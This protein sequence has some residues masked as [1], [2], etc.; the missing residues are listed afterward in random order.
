MDLE[1]IYNKVINIL[2]NDNTNLDYIQK[3]YKGYRDNVPE[4]MFPCI[5]VDV[6][7]APE[8][9]A[10]MPQRNQI[11]FTLEIIG[12]IKVFDVDKQIIGDDSIKGVLDVNEDIKKSLGA[13]SDLDGECLYFT[14]PDTRFSYNSF[15]FRQVEIDMQVTLRQNFTDRS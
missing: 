7:N 8:E 3:V 15:P 14:F 4:S 5:L 13:Y 1:S 2:E 11:N 6:V 12:V 9:S 10:T